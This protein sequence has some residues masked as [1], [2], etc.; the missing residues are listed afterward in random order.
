MKTKFLLTFLALVSI[1]LLGCDQDKSLN[2]TVQ[3]FSVEKEFSLQGI[4]EKMIFNSG[5]V[6]A[7]DWNFSL[8]SGAITLIRLSDKAQ[9]PVSSQDYKVSYEFLS[10]ADA[11][12]PWTER[13]IPCVDRAITYASCPNCFFRM[14]YSYGHQQTKYRQE[15]SFDSYKIGITNPSGAVLASLF[16][17]LENVGFVEVPL[18]PCK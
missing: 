11:T 12:G 18:T 7:Q 2:G 10:K 13:E 3:K 4:N 16:V 15:G 6:N 14:D 1:L 5:D 8:K 9:F 17:T